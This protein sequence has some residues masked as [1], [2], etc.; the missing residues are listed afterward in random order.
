M[1][2]KWE[3]GVVESALLVDL[4]AGFKGP[5]GGSAVNIDVGL[6]PGDDTARQGFGAASGEVVDLPRGEFSVPDVE[7]G[8][9]SHKRLG[10]IKPTTKSILE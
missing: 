7:M 3:G 1:D 5:F 10:G 4:A 9:F 2:L 6:R 8:Q